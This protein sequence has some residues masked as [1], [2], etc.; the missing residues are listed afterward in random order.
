M[1]KT[2]ALAA[3]CIFHLRAFSQV[4]INVDAELLKTSTA[5][6]GTA[7]PTSGLAILVASTTDNSFA[8]P[9]PTAYASGDDIVVGAWDLTG[10]FNTAGVLSQGVST[11]PS[12]NWNA[13]DQ[14]MLYWFPTLTLAQYN[15][16]T[17]PGGGT[18]YGQYR[19]PATVTPLEQNADLWITPGPSGTI[20][21]KFFTTDGTL[22]PPPGGGSSPASAG[23]ADYTTV[24]EPSSY[25]AILGGL[26][27]AGAIARRSFHKR[28]A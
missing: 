4:T 6:G 27:L 21:I 20:F 17:P 19:D 15:A 11:T 28:L 9:S 25:A 8:G 1:K 5:A 18:S 23:L 10:G 14:L 26:C 3:I 2:I 16:S 12:G 13:G 22:L 7:M 24:P